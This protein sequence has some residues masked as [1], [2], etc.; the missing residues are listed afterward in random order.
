MYLSRC[1]TPQEPRRKGEEKSA[2]AYVNRTLLI[3]GHIPVTSVFEVY[4]PSLDLSNKLKE[5]KVPTQQ[6]G[7]KRKHT[8]LQADLILR[9]SR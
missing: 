8:A 9:S 7:G 3:R 1:F 4:A 2:H 5:K 6:M